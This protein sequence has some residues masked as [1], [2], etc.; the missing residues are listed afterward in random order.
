MTPKQRMLAAYRGQ[1]ADMVPVAPE[2]WYYLPARLMGVDMIRF[3]REIPQSFGLIDPSLGRLAT[4]PDLFA[5]QAGDFQSFG[6]DD[7]IDP[8]TRLGGGANIRKVV[9]EP[10]FAVDAVVGQH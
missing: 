5:T 9:L 6:I 3:E 8:G 1:L 2:F 7:H 4:R 10:C